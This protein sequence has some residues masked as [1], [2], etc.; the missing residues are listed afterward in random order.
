MAST[1]GQ[2]IRALRIE[3]GLSQADL[4]GNLVSPSY[5]SLIEAGRRSPEREVLEGLARR[6]GCS[7]LYLES[8]VAPEEI[9]ERRL[10]LRFASIARAN[11]DLDQAREIFAELAHSATGEIRLEAI[12]GL[13]RTDEALGRLD[14]ALTQLDVLTDASRAGEPGAPGLLTLMTSKCRIY[15]RAG[16]V[17]RSIDVGEA[18]LTEIRA[19]G[20]EGTEDGIRLASTLAFSHQARGDMF[21]AQRLARRVIEQADRLDSRQAQASAYWSACTIAGARGQVTL[22][23][24][25]AAK[26]LALLSES[27]LPRNLASMRINY[28]WLLLRSDPPQLDEADA[29]LSQA[30]ETLAEQ[31][32]APLLAA[33]ETQ[34]AWSAVL[35][36]DVQRAARLADQAMARCTGQ[37]TVELQ[38]ARVV[39]G[40]TL[41]LRGEPGAGAECVGDAAGRLAELGAQPE[42][43]QAWRDLAEALIQ[44]GDSGQAIAALQ[45]AADCAG[46]LPSA[47][48]AAAPV[49]VS[50]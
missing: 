49:P 47:F 12:W 31:A 2:R 43:A 10:Q 41:V 25:L 26:T 28:A 27:P 23:L 7:V 30:Y 39:S 44:R 35:R 37:N 29:M 5:V 33:C 6:L 36:G 42:A 9:S 4:A 38:N 22:A 3:R 15:R 50:R 24:D 45:R 21:S 11:G 46:V 16:D 14:E 13:A 18:A 19:L 48:R 1:L 8:G 20:L 34:M 40:L 32:F 17:A